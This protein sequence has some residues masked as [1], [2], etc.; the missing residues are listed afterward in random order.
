MAQI[1]KSLLAKTAGMAERQSCCPL[2]IIIKKFFGIYQ[3]SKVLEAAVKE[4][5]IEKLPTVVF[6]EELKAR[7]SLD[8]LQRLP[9]LLQSN[10]QQVQINNQVRG[11]FLKEDIKE[12]LPTI[13]FDEELKARDSFCCVCLGEFEMKEELLQVPSCQHIF[14]RDCIGN[15]LSSSNTCPLCRSVVE[16]VDNTRLVLP[17]SQ[18]SPAMKNRK[19]NSYKRDTWPDATCLSLVTHTWTQVQKTKQAS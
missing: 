19:E 14:H 17:P 18:R 1:S 12:K 4:I 2:K 6:D 15:W 3:P 8:H 16:I 5:L 10:L 9:T 13:V 7:D 11:A